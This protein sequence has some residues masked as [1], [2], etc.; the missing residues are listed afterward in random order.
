M[1]DEDKMTLIEWLGFKRNPD[2][3]KVRW[4]GP[5]FTIIIIIVVVMLVPM[6]FFQFFKAVS[7]F[8]EFSSNAEKHAAIRNSGS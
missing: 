4:I 1:A 6:T 5:I 7:G 8:D 3:T 2:F